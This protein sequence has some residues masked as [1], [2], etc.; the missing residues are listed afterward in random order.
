[1]P[2]ECC[3]THTYISGYRI[4][5]DIPSS[6]YMYTLAILV[7]VCFHH[8]AQ[9]IVQLSP[10]TVWSALSLG[11]SQWSA[12]AESDISEAVAFALSGSGYLAMSRASSSFSS[13]TGHSLGMKVARD[14]FPPSP[15]D[16]D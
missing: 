6:S 10:G 13:G 14:A 11:A 7:Q 12:T 15:E 8:P 5:P 1:M 4:K 9:H 2:S 3:S 16:L